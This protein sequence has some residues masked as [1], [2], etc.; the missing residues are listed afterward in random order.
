MANTVQAWVTG[1]NFIFI[2]K[3]TTTTTTNQSAPGQFS[4]ANAGNKPA[5]TT[6]S[7]TS[8]KYLGTTAYCPKPAVS[9]A[10]RPILSSFRGGMQPSERGFMGE[11]ARLD[12]VLSRWDESVYAEARRVAGG[13]WMGA[14]EVGSLL[15][16]QKLGIIVVV[17][18]PYQGFPIYQ[19]QPAG[20]RFEMCSLEN[21]LILEE[22][23]TEGR[24]LGLSFHASS[25]WDGKQWRLYYTNKAAMPAIPNPDGKG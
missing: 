18:F 21:E 19:N 23:G 24:M 5:E 13:G 6:S 20:Y 10:W 14:T 8:F 1:P 16:A 22:G 2:G 15:M 25:V 11:E 12:M 3:T 4:G 9:R 17:L 7:S